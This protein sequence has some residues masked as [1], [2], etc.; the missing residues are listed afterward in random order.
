MNFASYDRN[1]TLNIIANTIA[2]GAEV[3]VKYKV[4]HH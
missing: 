3:R 1:V 4:I 2:L